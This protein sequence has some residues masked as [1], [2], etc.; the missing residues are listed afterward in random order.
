MLFIVTLPLII[1]ASILVHEAV[2]WF[3]YQNNAVIKVNNIVY[4]NEDTCGNNTLGCLDITWNE[5]ITN[6]QANSIMIQLPQNEAEAYIIQA[7]FI[8]LMTSSITYRIQK[9]GENDHDIQN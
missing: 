4:F 6:E 5:N 7:I 3:Q 8:M 9:A 2:H 1:I